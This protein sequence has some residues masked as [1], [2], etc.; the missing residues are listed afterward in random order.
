[1]SDSDVRVTPDFLTR[2]AG[3]FHDPSVGMIT[4]P[5][6]AVGG[7]SVWSRLEALG[8]NTELLGGGLVARMLE[9]MNFALGCTVGVRSSVFSPLGGFAYLQDYLA[10]EFRKG[11][12]RAH[13]GVPHF[14][15]RHVV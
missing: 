7:R 2:M 9:G 1:M 3:E 14:F 5:Y 6:R 12:R 11:R 10:E 4:C 8:M 13:L 15:S